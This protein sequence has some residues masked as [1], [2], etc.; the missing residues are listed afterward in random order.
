LSA[1]E[2][3]FE[4]TIYLIQKTNEYY[5][6]K[7]ILINYLH[8]LYHLCCRPNVREYPYDDCPYP[9]DY[10]DQNSMALTELGHS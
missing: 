2:S 3:I 7:G 1:G 8:V 4:K 5:I 10:L 9:E 6:E